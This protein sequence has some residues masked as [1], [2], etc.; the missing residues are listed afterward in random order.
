MVSHG[1]SSDLKAYILEATRTWPAQHEYS[2]CRY[3]IVFVRYKD[4]FLTRGATKI[5]SEQFLEF[6]PQ[7]ETSFYSA[8]RITEIIE[9][10]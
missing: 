8:I 10:R 1:L 3:G 6:D 2:Y 9:N 7:T 4:K 5:S